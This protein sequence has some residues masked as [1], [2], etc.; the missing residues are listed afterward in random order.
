MPIP[1][2]AGR[3]FEEMRLLQPAFTLWTGDSIYGSD[4]TVGEAE[5]EYHVF[6]ADAAKSNTPIFNAPGNHE[7]FDRP[8]LAALYEK[9]MGRLYG[10]F[11]Y[12]HSHFIALNTEEIGL[13]GGIGKEQ[14]DWL[15]RDL[16]ANKGAAH[17]FAFTTI[18]SS[19]EAERGFQQPGQPRRYS[20][21]VRQVRRQECVQRARPCPVQIG[22]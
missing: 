19:L 2:T 16:E 6:L 21:T 3:I 13:N 22:T 10:S 4:D 17:I 12:G 8:E 18:P 14:R 5:A 15:E 20:Q 9:C 1:P 7:I 11:D